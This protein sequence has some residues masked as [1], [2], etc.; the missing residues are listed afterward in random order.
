MKNLF[1]IDF[2]TFKKR[3]YFILILLN[4]LIIFSFLTLNY[5]TDKFLNHHKHITYTI[6]KI[7]YLSTKSHLYL[8]EYLHGDKKIYPQIEIHIT[9]AGNY[10]NI[11]EK[12]GFIKNYLYKNTHNDQFTIDTILQAKAILSEINQLRYNR[13]MNKIDHE[14]NEV[15]DMNYDLLFQ[16]L[17]ELEKHIDT[18]FKEMYSIYITVKYIVYICV[19]LVIL[20][21]IYLI[22]K[23]NNEVLEKTLLSYFDPLT[24]I[25]N[26]K[27]F[28]EEIA[29][30]LESYKRYK[31]P[32]IIIMFDI[33][34]FKNINDTYG[35][36]VGDIVL[37]DI[38]KLIT[39]HIRNDVDFMFRVGGEEFILL[40]SNTQLE[41]GKKVAEKIRHEVE[42]NLN[43]IEDKKIT[44]SIGLTQA[45]KDD[46]IDSIYKRVDK[47]L[48]H[49][50]NNGKNQV[51][52]S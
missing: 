12:G 3:I 2:S 15:Y 41:S 49:S 30:Q 43:S 1:S 47:L 16:S 9:Q 42:E 50:K 34:N 24:Q 40:C 29:K 32:F 10:L 7:K 21:G 22:Y 39:S 26:R 8:E 52:F 25:K 46:T 17:D 31:H 36:K 18:K 48:Y 14:L 33:D 20:F 27:G 44:I 45:Q 13:L 5:F 19:S 6:M 51:T 11:L 28:D 37:I 4:L 23:F 35:H 38:A